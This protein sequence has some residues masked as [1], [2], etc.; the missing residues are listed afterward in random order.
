VPVPAPALTP[1]CFL[2]ACI[3]LPT[4]CC[5]TRPPTA[6]LE[7]L[8]PGPLTPAQQQEQVGRVVEGVLGLPPGRL[9]EGMYTQAARAAAIA[10]D[11]AQ[12][13]C[14]IVRLC[15]PRPTWFTCSR[16]VQTHHGLDRDSLRA[17]PQTSCAPQ[18]AQHMRVL[19]QLAEVGQC[20]CCEVG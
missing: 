2:A 9:D 12:V 17:G 13:G 1:A 7:D 16:M 8:A 18:P 19:Q 6:A 3:L 5:H 20:W 14:T 15:M 11:A 4:C 10:G